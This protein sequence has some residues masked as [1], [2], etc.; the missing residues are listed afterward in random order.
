MAP[1]VKDPSII[2]RLTPLLVP[3]SH[4]QH[5]DSTDPD[6][7]AAD[8]IIGLETGSA[9]LVNTY[10]KGKPYPYKGHQGRDG[11][12]QGMA[13]LNRPNVF[14]FCPVM[15]GLPGLTAADTKA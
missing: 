9:R 11:I 2:E 13:P 10:M 1:V 8:P 6:K 5:K 14:P 12:L 4:L 15:V 3:Y 7:R